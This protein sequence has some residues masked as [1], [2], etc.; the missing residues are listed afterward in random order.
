MGGP[1]SFLSSYERLL[2]QIE[3]EI[4]ETERRIGRLVRAAHADPS[5]ADGKPLVMGWI[6]QIGSD[7]VPHFREFG[8]AAPAKAAFDEVIRAPFYTSGVDGPNHRF[9]LTIEL[10]GMGRDDVHMRAGTK[11]VRIDARH[12]HRR[13]QLRVASPVRID[14]RTAHVSF[15]NG[16]LQAAFRTTEPLPKRRGRLHFSDVE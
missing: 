12:E 11:I 14:P 7:G 6:L 2:V 15:A 10:P 1:E 8:T 13:Y 4:A 16:V 3:E 9:L 5:K